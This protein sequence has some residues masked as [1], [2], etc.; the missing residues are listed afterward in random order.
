MNFKVADNVIGVFSGALIAI[1]TYLLVPRDWGMIS[2]MLLGMFTGM[3][4]HFIL[5]LFIF[6]FFGSFEVMIPLH[7]IGMLVGMVSGML[8]TMQGVSIY[9]NAIIGGI[10]GWAVAVAILNSNKKLR[11]WPCR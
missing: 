6:P 9:W 5:M 8:A 4:L 11:G 3:V 1:I 7:I 2:G 10:M